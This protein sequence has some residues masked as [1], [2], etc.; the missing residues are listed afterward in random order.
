MARKLPTI[1]KWIN[2]NRPELYASCIPW[3]TNTD[4]KPRGF[5]YITHKGK[6][7][8]GY[9]LTVYLR[10]G[11]GKTEE[12]FEHTSSET[13]RTNQEVEDWLARYLEEN[14]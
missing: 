4:Y 3:T 11:P 2:E 8:K 5:R 10:T 12:I 1:A 7:R 6:G 14:A 13:Y 9:R